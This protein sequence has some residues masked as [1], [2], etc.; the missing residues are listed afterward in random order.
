MSNSSLISF[1]Q[2]CPLVGSQNKSGFR[3]IVDNVDFNDVFNFLC[4]NFG[5]AIP[6]NGEFVNDD[7]TIREGWRYFSKYE[8]TVPSGFRL[9]A[10]D[11]QIID[12][13]FSKFG[14]SIPYDPSNTIEYYIRKCVTP[15]LFSK[16]TERRVRKLKHLIAQELSILGHKV[17]WYHINYDWNTSTVYVTLKNTDFA[18][19]L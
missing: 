1:D 11:R 17:Q 4:D 19:K 6:K 7:W 14:F 5:E 13:I 3:L 18:I 12:S 9:I 2:F 15:L 8:Q 16:K 10:Y